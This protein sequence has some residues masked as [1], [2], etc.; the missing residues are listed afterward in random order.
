M[1][2]SSFSVQML[3]MYVMCRYKLD[4]D[5]GALLPLRRHGVLSPSSKCEWCRQVFRKCKRQP[6]I[7]EMQSEISQEPAWETGSKIRARHDT[8]PS[9]N[10][11]KKQGN[12]KSSCWELFNCHYRDPD[13][14]LARPWVAGSAL[15]S[16]GRHAGC[17]CSL[18]CRCSACTDPA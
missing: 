13:S 14:S 8:E 11:P 2:F 16:R 3:V 15:S 12:D 6:G 17:R 4:P 7:L 10:H 1:R 5:R 9:R 18:G